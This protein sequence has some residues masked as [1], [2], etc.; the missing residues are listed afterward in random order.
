MSWWLA[1]AWKLRRCHIQFVGLHRPGDVGVWILAQLFEVAFGVLGTCCRHEALEGAVVARC[2]FFVDELLQVSSEIGQGRV[3]NVD[4]LVDSRSVDDERRRDEHVIA[5]E[6]GDGASRI[7]EQAVAASDFGC[8]EGHVPMAWE[9]LSL[10]AIAD[11]L[12]AGE[13]PSATNIADDV[14]SSLELAQALMKVH[15]GLRCVD[16]KA[17]FDCLPDDFRCDRGGQGVARIGVTVLEPSSIDDWFD[18]VVAGDDGTDWCVA[19]AQAL[20]EHDDVGHDVPVLEAVEAA[21]APA[22]SQNVVDDEED[23]VFVA[24]A[25]DDGEVFIGGTA[26]PVEAPPMGSAMKAAMFAGSSTWT[27]RSSSCAQARSQ[28]G[29]SFSRGQW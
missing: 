25:F 14:V 24:D 15:A 7:D 22:A 19:P 4:D 3:E 11:E 23:V 16:D 28:A 6:T 2:R 21:G 12:D 27:S 13:Q 5:S 1:A 8:G 9:G 18:D 29:Y 20:G 26:P 10:A 17:S